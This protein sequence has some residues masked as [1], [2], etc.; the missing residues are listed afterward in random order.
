MVFM[1]VVGSFTPQ[2][3]LEFVTFTAYQSEDGGRG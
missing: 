2:I 1:S 3:L